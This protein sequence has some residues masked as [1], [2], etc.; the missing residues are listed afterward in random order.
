[1]TALTTVAPLARRDGDAVRV[2]AG[3]REQVRDAVLAFLDAA[4]TAT[5]RETFYNTR[6]EQAAAETAIHE[7]AFAVNRGLYGALLTLPGVNDRAAQLGLQKLLDTPH[8]GDG[9]PFLDAE[10]EGRLIA[11]L[12]AGL[13]P[14]RL[15]KL[16]V[17]LRDARVNNKRTRGLILRCVLGSDKLAFWAVKYRRKLRLALEHA[18]GRRVAVAVKHLTARASLDER[19]TVALHRHLGRWLPAG[20]DRAAAREAVCFILGGARDWSL[21]LLRAFRDARADLDKGAG[22]PL[23][24]L[25]GLRSR[26]HKEVPH[27][28]ALEIARGSGGVSEGQKLALQRSA[29]K[30]EVVLEFDPTKADL[31]RLY[32]YA[33]ECGM[34]PDVRAALDDK[35]RRAAA[36]LP[37]RYRRV[38]VVVD[39]SGSM[40]GTAQAKNRP[41]AVALALRDVLAASADE[42][43][44]VATNGGFDA[45]GL[46]RAE[47]DTDVASALALVAQQDVDAVFLLTDGYEN[48][49]AGRADEAL[50][51]LRGLGWAAPVYQMTPVLAAEAGGVRAVSEAVAPLPVARPEA[52]G[53]ALVRAALTADVE[54]GLLG[55]LRLTRPLLN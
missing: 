9:S 29:A 3:A 53:L 20:A 40:A 19:Q 25:G 44:V 8:P 27:A 18:W 28:R 12:A 32:V 41:L 33:L 13:P 17:A 1:M 38:G 4:A 46:A 23:E 6:D 54:L 16:F 52:L 39:T 14:Q 26:F 51:A 37:V 49:P 2:A 31:T 21:P 42:A 45:L 11:R 36:G 34:T 5:G 22:L 10:Q 15:F 48:A 50:R 43:R 7:A 30:H 47:G 55:L 24:V 35:A